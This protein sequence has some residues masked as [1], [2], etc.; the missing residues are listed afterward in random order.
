MGGHKSDQMWTILPAGQ[1]DRTVNIVSAFVSSPGLRLT[2]R[3]K[4]SCLLFV[5]FS[6][7]FWLLFVCFQNIKFLNEANEMAVYFCLLVVQTVHTMPFIPDY[8]DQ[9]D[10]LFP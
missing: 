10:L 1:C 8:F 3:A 5:I 4:N 6:C 9:D 2:Q 7:C